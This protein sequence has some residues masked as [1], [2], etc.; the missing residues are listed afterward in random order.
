MFKSNVIYVINASKFSARYVY[1]QCHIDIYGL[2]TGSS[3]A[4]QNLRL[5]RVYFKFE[6]Q[7]CRQTYT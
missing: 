6:L 7:F 2:V 1:I 5:T 3:V 4:F